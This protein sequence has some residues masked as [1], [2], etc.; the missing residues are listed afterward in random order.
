MR[1]Q[2]LTQLPVA[3]TI[4]ATARHH[5]NIPSYQLRLPGAKGFADLALDAIAFH[6]LFDMTL[7][8][9][10][11]KTGIGFLIGSDQH[12][13]MRMTEAPGLGENVPEVG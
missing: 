12:R 3:Q 2:H 6:R 10:Q 4:G 5:H 1:F 9:R 13:Q 8:N 11:T 7:G